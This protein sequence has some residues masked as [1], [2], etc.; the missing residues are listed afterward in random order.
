[1]NK[2]PRRVINTA[3]F[4]LSEASRPHIM[5]LSAKST[6]AKRQPLFYSQ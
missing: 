1:M 2:K 5:K 3:G 4:L 6:V